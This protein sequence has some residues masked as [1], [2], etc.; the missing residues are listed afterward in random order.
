MEHYLFWSGTLFNDNNNIYLSPISNVHRDTSIR[1]LRVPKWNNIYSG[2]E[3]YLFLKG[4]LFNPESNI[5]YSRME[6]YY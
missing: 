2:M 4:K 1:T 5:I 6:H 3:L